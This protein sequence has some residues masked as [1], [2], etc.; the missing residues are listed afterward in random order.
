MALAAIARFLHEEG[1]TTALE[2]FTR[3]AQQVA[4]WTWPSA[5]PASIDLRNLVEAHIAQRKQNALAEEKKRHGRGQ[6][7]AAPLPSPTE[8]V[9]PGPAT[10]PYSLVKTHASLHASN[11]LSLSVVTLP[12]RS[13]STTQAEYVTQSRKLLCSTAADKTVVFSEPES[14]EMVEV[15]EPAPSAAAAAAAPGADGGGNAAAG[16]SAAVLCTAQ[17]PIEQRELVSC[18]MDAK[19][20]IWDLL[21][22]RTVQ[23]LSHHTKFVVRCAYSPKGQYLA[24]CSYD[25]TVRVYRRAMAQRQAEDEDTVEVPLI[26]PR[27]ELVHTVETRNNPEALVFVR[28]PL[29]PA[30]DDVGVRSKDRVLGERG[31][32]APSSDNAS[33]SLLEVPRQRT[34]LVYTMRSDSFVHYLALPLDAD[35]D[36][37]EAQARANDVETRVDETGKRL[38]H[39][40]VAS[41][42]TVTPAWEVVSFNTN[43]T[44]EDLHVSYSLLFLTLHPLG[45]HIG[46]QTG[47]HSIPTTGYAPASS[48]LSRILLLPVLSSKRTATLWTGV[49][50]SGFATN[51]HAW[52][53]DGTGAWLTGEDGLLRLVDMAGKVRACIPAHGAAA[54]AHQR[55]TLG[56]LLTTSWSRG[57]NTIIKDVVVLD[58]HGDRIASCGFDRCIRVVEKIPE[59]LS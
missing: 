45:T 14:G 24:T 25:K 57:G 47:D 20:I 2:A 15:L 22:R 26:E 10:L 3:E 50:S 44:A 36:T 58:E 13:F 17:H 18:G 41:P 40:S 54:E 11:I 9:L 55:A 38:A 34:W 35:A 12:T 32:S 21:H 19:V 53:K 42:F 6:L 30:V 29:A 33:P 8:L 4:G 31:E 59:G 7:S 49:A 46:I 43:L 28:A 52:L 51:R 1:Y 23:T 37:D 39:M 27:Y 16:H 5:S 56:T 48:S